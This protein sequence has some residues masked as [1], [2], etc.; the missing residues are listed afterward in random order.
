M[1]TDCT[2]DDF[3][4]LTWSQRLEWLE[5]FVQENQLGDWFDDIAG[6]IE[7]LSN[8]PDYQDMNGWAAYID[9]GILQ[10]INDGMRIFNNQ[11]PIGDGGGAWSAFFSAEDKGW[12]NSNLNGLIA[13][14][15]AGEQGGVDYAALL[16]ETIRRHDASDARVQLKSYLFL[17]GANQYRY[18]GMACR[19]LFSCNSEFTDPRTA[20]ETPFFQGLGQLPDVVSSAVFNFESPK[21]NWLT[22]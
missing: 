21:I 4:E 7:I 22:P 6:A 10:A 17:K 1:K 14:R 8:D 19:V 5:L 12:E 11:D 13:L 15:L 9:A 16:P 2:V 18:T 20:V 3:H